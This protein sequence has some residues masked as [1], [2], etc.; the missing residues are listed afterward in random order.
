MRKRGASEGWKLRPTTGPAE[1]GIIKV[2]RHLIFAHD[3][4]KHTLARLNGCSRDKFPRSARHRPRRRGKF[5]RGT[6][7][8][9]PLEKGEKKAWRVYV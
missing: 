9:R 2:I 4:D 7:R 5:L 1:T 6:F 3:E 8:R